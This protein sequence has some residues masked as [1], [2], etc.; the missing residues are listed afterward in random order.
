[1]VH[2]M[3]S[4]LDREFFLKIKSD[5]HDR[6]SIFYRSSGKVWF[7]VYI[8]K[9]AFMPLLKFD[10]FCRAK[11]YRVFNDEGIKVWGYCIFGSAIG[12]NMVLMLLLLKA[13]NQK[14][15]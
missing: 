9:S 14:S 5:S 12:H 4:S 6:N 1:M 7:E 2:P 3:P 15:Y 11:I 8:Y 13:Y 10:L